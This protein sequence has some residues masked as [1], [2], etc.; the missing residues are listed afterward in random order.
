MKDQVNCGPE[1]LGGHPPTYLEEESDNKNLQTSHADDEERLNHAKVDDAVLGAV[2]GR[3]VAVLTCAEVLLVS[4]DCG[5]LARNLVHRLLKLVCLLLAGSLF[6]GEL[7]T[8]LALDLL[9][10]MWLVGCLL[11]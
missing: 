7:C 10:K 1:W 3:K 4:R 6:R 9:C 8:R 5:Q 11:W 2:D